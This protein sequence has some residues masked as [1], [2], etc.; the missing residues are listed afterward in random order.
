MRGAARVGGRTGHL[1]TPAEEPLA[2]KLAQ[3]QDLGTY[4]FHAIVEMFTFDITT[5]FRYDILK[6]RGPIKVTPRRRP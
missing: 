5:H 2:S 1:R 3:L 6:P 4:P